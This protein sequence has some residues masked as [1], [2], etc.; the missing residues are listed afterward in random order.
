MVAEAFAKTPVGPSTDP[1][2]FMG[3]LISKQ[4]QERV[5]QYI[6]TGIDEGATLVTGGAAPSVDTV[7]FGTVMCVCVRA[8]VCVWV[9]RGHPVAFF[10]GL[11]S[12][13]LFLSFNL[14]LR[15]R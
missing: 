5:R 1:N 2:A 12:L 10:L 11:F 3:P 15:Y 7:F 6:Q 13:F 14:S 4:Q 9:G 8:C